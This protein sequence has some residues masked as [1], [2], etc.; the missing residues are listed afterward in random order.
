MSA[1]CGLIIAIYCTVLKKLVKV[2]LFK[3]CNPR[4]IFKELSEHFALVVKRNMN[5]DCVGRWLDIATGNMGLH[6]K[7]CRNSVRFMRS[8]ECKSGILCFKEGIF[9]FDLLVFENSQQ[10]SILR[11]FKVKIMLSIFNSAPE[12]ISF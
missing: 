3:T 2:Q 11:D 12:I 9:K 10:S 8:V 7:I 1:D 6:L 4:N 5:S